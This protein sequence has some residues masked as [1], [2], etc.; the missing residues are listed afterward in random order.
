MEKFITTLSIVI[1]VFKASHYIEDL[2]IK[3]NQTKEILK[4]AGVNLIEVI[5]VC[6]E[7]LDDSLQILKNIEKEYDFLETIELS[8]NL[9]QHLATS[10]GIVASSGD[11]ICTLDEDLQHDPLLIIDLLKRATQFSHDLVY[12]KS[13]IGTHRKSFYRDISS[14][15]AKKIISTLTGQNLNI[16]SSFRLIRGNVARTSATSMDKFQYLDNLLFYLTS[17]KRR[18]F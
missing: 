1:P 18:S 4:K 9:G 11:W 5:C 12:A 16:I 7:P 3:I 8:A 13:R 14:K 2:L 17:I 10:A 15:F 6:D